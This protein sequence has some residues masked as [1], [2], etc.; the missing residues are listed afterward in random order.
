M[1]LTVEAIPERGLIRYV[2]GDRIDQADVDAIVA[3]LEE[4]QGELP[5]LP[6]RYFDLRATEAIDIEYANLGS[7]IARRQELG[8]GEGPVRGAFVATSAVA[9][10]MV[11]MYRSLIG[12]DRYQVRRFNHLHEAADWLEVP[13]NVLEA[14]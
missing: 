5:K 7:F 14:A 6:R 2:F 1:S 4:H 11:N 3:F 13:A 10:G 12:D 8:V 9:V